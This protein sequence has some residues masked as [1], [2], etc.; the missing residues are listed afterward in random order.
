MLNVITLKVYL[1]K[2][3]KSNTNY[4]EQEEAKNFDIDS[5]LKEDEEHFD[6]EKDMRPLPETITT[7]PFKE[8][9][10]IDWDL[11]GKQMREDEDDQREKDIEDACVPDY[12]Q[13]D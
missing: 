11:E 8:E 5:G 3:A 9:K 13:R 6:D 1:I 4:Q 2:M 10:D 7:T 12:T